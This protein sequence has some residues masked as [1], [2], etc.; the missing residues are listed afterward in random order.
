VISD[1]DKIVS[2]KVDTDIVT[3][4][5]KKAVEMGELKNSITKSGGNL[6][7]FIGEGLV[8]KYLLDNEETVR[9][10]N[11][12]DYDIVLNNGFAIDVKTKRTNYKPKLEYECSVASLNTKQR[13]DVYVFT[14]VKG[15]MSVGWLLGFLPKDEYFEKANFMEKGAIDPSNGWQVKSDCYQVPISDLRPMDELTSK[16]IDS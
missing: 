3:H 16:S 11:T 10:S 12:Y 1:I 7:G 8:H 4:A 2:L 13:C 9:W 5:H 14:R 15:D 6:V